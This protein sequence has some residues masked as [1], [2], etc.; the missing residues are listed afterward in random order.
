MLSPSNTRAARITITSC[1]Q[2]VRQVT[3]NNDVKI[4]LFWWDFIFIQKVTFFAAN[5]GY[6]FD[7]GL[8]VHNRL[9]IMNSSM[10]FDKVL[11]QFLLI[12]FVVFPFSIAFG[13]P[14]TEIVLFDLKISGDEISAVNGS[15]ITL[16]P[17]AYDNQPFFHPDKE[18][19]YYASADDAGRT[20]I[21]VYDY[22]SK[23]TSSLTKTTEREYSPTVTPD[24]KFVSCIIQRDNGAQDLGKYPIDGGEATVIIN[25]LTIG[26]HAWLDDRTLFMFVLGEP[27]TFH[28]YNVNNKTDSIRAMDIGRSLLRIPGTAA[29]SFVQKAKDGRWTINQIDGRGTI[30]VIG[31]TISGREDIAWVPGGR[32]LMTDG[33]TV[34]VGKPGTTSWKEIK[35][36]SVVYLKNIT[37]LAVS[38]DGSKLALVI[39]E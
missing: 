27:A 22:K 8:T 2:T 39:E 33:R 20:D 6:S 4:N 16:H 32:M 5:S 28:Q 17:G 29:V 11:K 13:Q 21:R 1:D 14:L 38:A 7:W 34:Y 12:A 23:Q 19:M 9:K 37:R 31:E 26:Y 35:I 15:N 30:S 18:L 10:H 3:N 36:S 24:K 25:N